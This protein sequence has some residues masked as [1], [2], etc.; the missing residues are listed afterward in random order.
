MLETEPAKFGY[1]ENYVENITS[2]QSMCL[3]NVLSVMFYVKN[4]II[5]VIVCVDHSQKLQ[6]GS[7]A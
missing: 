4:K 3:N 1:V 7:T 5:D 6:K 2:V